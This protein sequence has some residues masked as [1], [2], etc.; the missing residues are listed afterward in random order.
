LKCFEHLKIEP[1]IFSPRELLKSKKDDREFL[2]LV[3]EG[4]VLWDKT[5]D[6]TRPC[7]GEKKDRVLK[8]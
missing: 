2:S 5:N 6:G 1:V 3:R 4:I 8:F 7:S